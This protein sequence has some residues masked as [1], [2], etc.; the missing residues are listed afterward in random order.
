MRK[1]IS[2]ISGRWKLHNGIEIPYFGLGVFQAREGDQVFEAIHAAFEA[3]Y[4]LID[5]AA[6]YNNEIGVGKAIR[7]SNIKREELFVTTKI[8]NDDQ[9][10]GDVLSAFNKSLDKLGL[11]YVDLYLIHWP[12]KGQYKKTWKVLEEIYSEGRVKAIGVSNFLQHHLE[13]LMEHSEIT[14]MVNQMEFHPYLI[15]QDLLDYCA[16]HFI[17]Y[18]SWSPLMLGKVLEIQALKDL[19]EKYSKNVVQMVLRWNLQKGVAT[20]PKSVKKERI[21]GNADIFDFEISGSDMMLID[22]LDRAYRTG[23]DPDNF[24]F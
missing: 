21:I 6:F 15:Q 8:W 1:Q 19:A 7:D 24:P 9:R 10:S 4:R 23:D 16:E 2:D 18:Q 12:V 11:D 5:T 22:G 14:P 3:G 13:D 20:I 17:Q